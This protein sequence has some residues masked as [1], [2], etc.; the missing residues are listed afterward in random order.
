MQTIST[1]PL[2]DSAGFIFDSNDFAMNSSSFQSVVPSPLPTCEWETG[3]EDD[4]ANSSS[5]VDEVLEEVRD[6]DDE[7]EFEQCMLGDDE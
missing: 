7:D 6:N 2:L 5:Q 1:P 3:E 4:Q